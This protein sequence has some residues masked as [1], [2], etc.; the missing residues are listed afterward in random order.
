MPA[1]ADAAADDTFVMLE[2]A[3]V[4]TTTPPA[5]ASD[6]V[7]PAAPTTTPFIEADAAWLLVLLTDPAPEA[8]TLTVPA[9]FQSAEA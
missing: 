5:N 2:L 1:V 4:V 7:R 3:L 9:T 6:L 8:A